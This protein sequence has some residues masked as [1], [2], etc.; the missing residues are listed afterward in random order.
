MGKRTWLASAGGSLSAASLSVFGAAASA[1]ASTSATVAGYTYVNGNT[2][3]TSRAA[4]GRR[5]PAPLSAPRSRPAPACV[6]AGSRV[7]AS[8][9]SGSPEG[10]LV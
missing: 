6:A 10:S 9:S 1:S 5:V 3:R 8:R 7:A 4:V 2:A